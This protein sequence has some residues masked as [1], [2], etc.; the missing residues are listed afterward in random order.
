MV[1]VDIPALVKEVSPAVVNVSTTQD[2]AT[3][4]LNGGSTSGF[5]VGMPLAG[6]SNIPG[7]ATVAGIVNGSTFTISLPVAS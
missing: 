5:F 6:N 3:V 4:T 7:G 1:P 2:S